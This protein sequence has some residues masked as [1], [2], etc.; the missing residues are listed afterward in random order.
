MKHFLSLFAA[1]VLNQLIILR[2]YFLNCFDTFA[3]YR[4][5]IEREKKVFSFLLFSSYVASHLVFTQF[6]LRNRTLT[7]SPCVSRDST[8]KSK[9]IQTSQ[10]MEFEWTE[11]HTWC[12]ILFNSFCDFYK[13]AAELKSFVYNDGWSPTHTQHRIVD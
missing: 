6:F 4:D 12:M 3:V 1:A 11:P 5:R 9:T 8:K 2:I 13:F 7:L 10:Q